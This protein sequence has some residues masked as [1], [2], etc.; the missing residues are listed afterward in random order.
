MSN[1]SE[2]DRGRLDASA[3]QTESL[4]C[5]V[6]PVEAEDTCYSCLPSWVEYLG[7]PVWV[8]SARSTITYINDEALRLLGVT[9][10]SCLGK[11]CYEVIAGRDSEENAFCCKGC[12]MRQLVE[13]HSPIKPTQLQVTASDGKRHWL[14]LVVIPVKDRLSG[15]DCLVHCAIDDDRAH[16]IQ[17]YL[18]K[19][20]SRTQ[21][22]HGECGVEHTQRFNLTT[23]EREILELLTKDET[24]WS[25]AH[26][27]NVSYTTVRNHVQ[28]ILTKLGVHSI[29]EA[30]AYFLVSDSTAGEDRD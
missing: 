24:L 2:N 6:T 19:V 18:A 3:E 29:I 7:G 30:V 1:G 14:Q 8:S 10:E 13:S 23:R 5:D 28:H 17:A 16:A 11:P 25:I 15:S 21:H 22:H 26:S 12:M 27:L 9:A 20:T 4:S